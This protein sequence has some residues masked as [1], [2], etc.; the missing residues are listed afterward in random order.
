MHIQLRTEH[1]HGISLLPPPPETTAYPPSLRSGRHRNLDEEGRARPDAV[2]HLA[3]HRPARRGDGDRA[4]C[5]D[6]GRAHHLHLLH[7]AGQSGSGRRARRRAR[8]RRGFLLLGRTESI[9]GLRLIHPLR[10]RLRD[11][12]QSTRAHTRRDS[13]KIRWRRSSSSKG[14]QRGL[15]SQALGL[16]G[17]RIFFVRARTDDSVQR[18]AGSR[19][20]SPLLLSLL[21]ASSLGPGR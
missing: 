14:E 13:R 18:L 5:R 12:A 4:P 7:S 19:R 6:V 21:L 1:V 16:T 17:L 20:C 10:L 15:D 3:G 8:P 11:A 2:R 9:S